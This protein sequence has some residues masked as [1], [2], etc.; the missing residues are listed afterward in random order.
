MKI[1]FKDGSQTY[2]EAVITYLAID[3][4]AIEVV[5]ENDNFYITSQ[6][7]GID[8]TETMVS[9]EKYS[10]ADDLENEVEPLEVINL[11]LKELE[12][13][14]MINKTWEKVNLEDNF[15]GFGR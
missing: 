9:L 2:L 6:F 1:Q 12:V 14:V 4:S 7:R 10:D 13:N 8:D 11:K 3:E 5:L 15:K